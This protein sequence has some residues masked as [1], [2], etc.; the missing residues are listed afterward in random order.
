VFPS[1][2][3]ASARIVLDWDVDRA[4]IGI[5]DDHPLFRRG[6]GVTL[7]K[8]RDLDVVCEVGSA[9]EVLAVARNVTMDLAIIDMMMPETS[10]F[11]LCAE[12]REIQPAC[13][14][15]ALSVIDE[16]GLIADILRAGASGYALKTQAVPEIVAAIHQVLGGIRYLPPTIPRDVIEAALSDTAAHPLV[17]L[18]RRERQV[19]ELLI[20]GR[21]NDEIATGLFISVRTAETHR[22]RIG[23]KLSAYSI[24][25]MQ[26]IAARHGGLPL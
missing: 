4:R 2:A 24:I 18:T 21:S 25:Q 10:G 11:T 15:L 7:Q 8:E 22:Q 9:I 20:R 23:K 5:V 19:F 3:T 14:V 1:L 16:V 6:L 26:R 12:I 17:Q 13:K